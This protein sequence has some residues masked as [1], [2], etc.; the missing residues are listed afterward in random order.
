MLNGQKALLLFDNAADDKQILPLLPPTSCLL[1]I[2]SR[3]HFQAPGLHPK[4]LEVLSSDD[5]RE[6]MLKIAP[7]LAPTPT[8]PRDVQQVA[9]EGALA[10]DAIAKMCGYLPQALRAAASLLAVSEDLDPND[11]LQQLGDERTRLEK[12]GAEGIE[13]SVEA[14]LSL[15]YARLTDGAKQVFC[16]LSVFPGDFDAAAEVAVCEDEGHN[17][18]SELL[19]L[20]LVQYDPT[21]HRYKLHDLVRLFADKRLSDEARHAAQ[22]HHAKYYLSVLSAADDLYMHGGDDITRGLA[23]FDLEWSNIQS[24][25]AWAVSQMKENNNAIR[26]CN[27]YAN[28]WY[29]LNLRLHPREYIHWVNDA[30]TAARQLKHQNY[31]GVHL[32]NLGVAYAELGETRKAIEYHNQRLEIAR[33]IGDRR[34]EGQ[35]LGNLGIAYADLGETRKAIEFYEQVLTIAREIGDRRSEGNAL[36][37]L[38][39]AYA[40][41]GETRKAIEYH[42]QALKIDRE[43]GDKHGEGQDLGNLG[44]AYAAQGETRKAIK[45]YNQRLEIA[46][47]IG[48]RRGEGIAL[49]NMSL[50]RDKLGERDKAIK[51]AEAALRIFEQIEDPNAAKVRK[52]LAEWKNNDK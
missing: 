37:N 1:L 31:E 10:V 36:G 38:G 30:L 26:L 43:I 34:G 46:R 32:G 39:V 40:D 12:I 16:K 20:S 5:A 35:A 15:S 44:N 18:L 48:D 8:L 9:G 21:A 42:E 28:N 25:R 14:S 2:T 6:L 17:H 52:Q 33:E 22:L 51:L 27:E 7:R 47:E 29:V 3:Q 24:G 41:L 19:R 13:L 11:Y 45:L 23:L 50:A 49:G 4:N